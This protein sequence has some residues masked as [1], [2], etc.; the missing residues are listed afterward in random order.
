MEI[1]QPRRRIRGRY[2]TAGA[3]L[4]VWGLAIGCAFAAAWALNPVIAMVTHHG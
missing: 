4:V 3:A 2:L 1:F